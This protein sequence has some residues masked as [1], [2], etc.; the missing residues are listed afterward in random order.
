M[1]HLLATILLM[2]LLIGTTRNVLLKLKECLLTKQQD[3]IFSDNKRKSLLGETLVLSW[4]NHR[5][6][7]DHYIVR[8]E[9][10]DEDLDYIQTRIAEVF[11]KNFTWV[12]SRHVASSDY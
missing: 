3:M 7:E 11:E 6:D 8:R 4:Y 12:L 10:R 1:T 2:T 5:L 9:C